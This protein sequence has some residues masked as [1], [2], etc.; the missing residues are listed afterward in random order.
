MNQYPFPMLDPAF[1]WHGGFNW[2]NK[3]L[4][5][6]IGS[7]ASL[8]SLD[9]AAARA[10]LSTRIASIELL[11]YHSASFRNGGSWL[12]K[13]PSMALARAYVHDV[14]VPRVREGSAIAIVTRQAR[15]WALPKVRGIITYSGQQ[16]RAAHLT[17]SSPGGAAIVRHLR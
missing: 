13:L 9:Y 10:R 4:A 5:G 2:W 12:R 11:P 3:K 15:L 14:V 7:L 16:A 6:V 17:P 8:W 1:A